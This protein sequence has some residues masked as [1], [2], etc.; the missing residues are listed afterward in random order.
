MSWMLEAAKGIKIQFIISWLILPLLLFIALPGCTPREKIFTIGV[1]IHSSVHVKALEGF[2]SGMTKL[3][4]V[5]DKNIRYVFNGIP[6]DNEVA[7]DAELKRL[8]DQGADLLLTTGTKI[9][10]RAKKIVDGTDIPVVFCAG[11]DTTSWGLVK[12]MNHPG[13]NVTGVEMPN[14]MAKLMELMVMIRPELKK[15]YMPYNP[16]D[17]IVFLNL[18]EL[19]RIASQVGVT[20]IPQEVHSVE[21]AIVAIKSIQNDV[22][23]IYRVPSLTLDARNSELSLA[24]INKGIPMGAI[25]PLDE[26]VLITLSA[27]FFETGRQTARLAHQIRLGTRPADLP[28]ERSEPL[29]SIN[30]KTAEKIGIHIPD[31]ILV[32]A[33]TIIR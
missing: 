30:L 7:F 6:A 32:R 31:E 10:L 15:I 17:N 27:D 25:L 20:L 13:G 33:N 8:V 18:S 14:T 26:S 29:L 28:V 23:A 16:D 2:K 24:A 12:S 9:S 19:K 11:I 22:C 21:K 5:E 4:Y 1:C 3:G